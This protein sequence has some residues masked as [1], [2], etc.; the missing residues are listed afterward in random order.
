MPCSAT[1]TVTGEMRIVLNAPPPR[2]EPPLRMKVEYGP[3]V[4]GEA[5]EELRLDLEQTISA[6]LRVR[7]AIQLVPPN[8]LPKDPSKKAILIEKSYE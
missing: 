7:P 1:S 5:R 3:G 8:S 4:E 2:V 6:R